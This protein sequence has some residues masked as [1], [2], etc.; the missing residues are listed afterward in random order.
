MFS[1][2]SSAPIPSDRKGIYPVG[3]AFYK[4]GREFRGIGVN[5]WGVFIN[6]LTALG[7]TSDYDADFTAIKQTWGIPF[8]RC[9]VGMYSHGTWYGQWH[10]NKAAFYAKLDA[11]VAKAE[12]LGL[13]IIAVL[14]WGARSIT[15]AC[16][17]IHGQY[18]PVKNLAYK[19]TKAWQL[20]ETFVTEVVTRYKDSAAIWGWELGNEVINS[21]GAEYWP[22][23]KLDGTGTDGGGTALPGNLNWGAKPGG[24]TYPVTDK[25]GMA[26]WQK[27]SQDFVSLV[28]RLDENKRCLFS[29]SPIGNSFA[30]KAQTANTLAADTQSDWSGVP[31]T[32]GIPWIAYRDKAF[33]TLTQ[34]IYPMN[35]SDG[36]FFSGG[37][38]TCA[39]LITLS[40]G[41]A[42]QVGKPLCLGEFGAT[43][44]GD[45]VDENSTDL[46]TEQANFTAALG[47][48]V[49]SGI[50]LSA[51]W[52]YGGDLAGASPWMR[53]KLSDS[54]RT[55]QLTAI[56]AQNAAYRSAGYQ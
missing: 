5:H 35:P 43:Y 20:F 48:V 49:S 41:W 2:N 36:R 1:A 19:H 25:M 33:N 53:W 54:A 50:G 8:V 47:A 11:V 21:T 23:W 14:V 15:D 52:N 55:Y 7:V 42:D 45:P 56:A 22:T 3:A 39:E 16:Y 26:E 6:E 44:W 17:E 40:K 38:K 12:A 18:E 24:G 37:E 32:E 29:G 51:V 10:Q 30:V 46:A 34:H 4:G 13:G 28:G 31:S 9:A 27:F